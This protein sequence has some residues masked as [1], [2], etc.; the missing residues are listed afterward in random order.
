[1]NAMIKRLRYAYGWAF[2]RPRRWAFSRMVWSYRPIWW[3]RRHEWSGLEWPNIHWWILYCTVFRFCEWLHWRA[4]HAFCRHD[5]RGYV[6]PIPLV[7][8]VLRRIGE[9]TSGWAVSG[10]ECF[11]CASRDGNPVELSDDDTGTTFI[12]EDSG[13]CST[14]MGTDHWFRGTTICPKCGYRQEY[15]DGSL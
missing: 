5:E 14:D 6:K 8:K 2:V 4:W 13:T 15:G 10:G 11:H 7:A 3:F 12:L 1:M 9:T